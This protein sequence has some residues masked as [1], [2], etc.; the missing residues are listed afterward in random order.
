MEQATGS[1]QLFELNVKTHNA[2]V[3][4]SVKLTISYVVVPA[5]KCENL[6]LLVLL[7]ITTG[8]PVMTPGND[9][10]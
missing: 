2:C 4:V 5:P 1:S 6:S 8:Q 7:L 9:R 3:F 10:E